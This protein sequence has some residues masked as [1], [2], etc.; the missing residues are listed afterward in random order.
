MKFTIEEIR[1]YLESQN[2]FGDIF[3]NLSEANIL[4]ANESEDL[5]D[6]FE[7]EYYDEDEDL[8]ENEI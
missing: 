6:H 1:K 4:K 7:E 3:Y 8:I 5:D 2:S